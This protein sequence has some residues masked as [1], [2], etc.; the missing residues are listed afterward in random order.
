MTEPTQ[1]Q[2]DLWEKEAL[3]K[4]PVLIGTATETWKQEQN[5]LHTIYRS[6]YLS[7]CRARWEEQ[8]AA[9][10]V[11]VKER[12]TKEGEYLVLISEE[13][14]K[15]NCWHSRYHTDYW[16]NSQGGYWLTHD[17]WTHWMALPAPPAETPPVR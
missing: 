16:Y 4:F 6:I 14:R 8:Q 3:N 10:W 17:Y 11:S 12:P 7:A 5:D 1:Q 9:G 2:I 15:K 13:Q